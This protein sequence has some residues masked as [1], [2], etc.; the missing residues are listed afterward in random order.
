MDKDGLEKQNKT[1]QKTKQN[2]T[3]LE[4]QTTFIKYSSQLLCF[5]KTYGAYTQEK[6]VITH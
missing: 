5:L 6:P 3:Q 1:K 2:W 4:T